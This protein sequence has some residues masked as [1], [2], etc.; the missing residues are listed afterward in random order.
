[1][2][3]AQC[4]CMRFFSSVLSS[5][6]NGYHIPR[7]DP[8]TFAVFIFFCNFLGFPILCLAYIFVKETFLFHKFLYLPVHINS[9]D[10]IAKMA[11]VMILMDILNSMYRTAVVV[12]YIRKP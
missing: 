7:L 3:L 5:F 4:A 8:E 11:V 12:C 2:L 9:L 10:L 6:F 1:M